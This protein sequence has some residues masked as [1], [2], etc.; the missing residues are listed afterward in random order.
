MNSRID[1]TI[2]AYMRWELGDLEQMIAEHP[3]FDAAEARRAWK[4]ISDRNDGT[5]ATT[6]HE[7]NI[8][9]V[10]DAMLGMSLD[11]ESLLEFVPEIDRS[12][13]VTAIH[14]LIDS[15]ALE[16]LF[17]LYTANEVAETLGL[18]PVYVRRLSKTE[19]AGWLYGDQWL[20][21]PGDI[22]ALRNRK[23]RRRKSDAA[24][25]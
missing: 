16:T 12:S 17:H 14:R 22:A 20:Y 24:K 1:S 9:E 19:N 2:R 13:A 7:P 4:R 10:P 21:T 8:T 15:A 3:E 5:D 18:N 25:S 23:D 11:I 6:G